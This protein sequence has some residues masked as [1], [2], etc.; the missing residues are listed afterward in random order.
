MIA[1][2]VLYSLLALATVVRH[3]VSSGSKDA[4]S[5]YLRGDDVT[6]R[7]IRLTQ[8]GERDRIIRAS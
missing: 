8:D 6:P 1:F 4:V 2:T 5:R 7:R 3:R